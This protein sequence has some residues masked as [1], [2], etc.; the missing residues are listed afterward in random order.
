MTTEGTTD[1]ELM[2]KLGRQDMSALGELVRRHQQRVLDLAFRTLGKWD[3]AEDITQEAFLRVH[4][5][6]GNYKPTA[7]FTTWLY[8]I[9]VNLC[10]DAQRSLA[11]KAAPLDGAALDVEAGT[12]Y[13]AA[14]RKELVEFVKAA[15]GRLPQ[16]QRMALILHRYQ[17]LSHGEI[18]EVT[19]WSSS[20][21]ESLLVRA[22]AN[23][24]EKL[25]KVKYYVE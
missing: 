25:D 22:Y 20:A 17:G 13:D 9:V 5:A 14:E 16:R 21:V 1:E 6:A 10:F 3:L 23:L 15:V 8:R 18:A 24:R 4:R 11:R 19:G 12:D 2:L 7:R